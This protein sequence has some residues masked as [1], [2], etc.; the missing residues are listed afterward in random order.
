M[1][2]EPF[3]AKR[4]QAKYCGETCKKRAQRGGIAKT[5]TPVVTETPLTGLVDAVTTEL[6]AADRLNTVA[7]QHA[8]EL[9]NRIVNSPGMNTGVASL[10]TR[11]SAVLAEAL[12]GSNVAV[13]PVDEL[14][15]RRD[16][17]LAAS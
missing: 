9:A 10:S 8:L 12:Q 16:A 14:R 2:S 3:E 7:G 17:K 13:D 1:C 4:P 15:A 5:A 6:R 11:L